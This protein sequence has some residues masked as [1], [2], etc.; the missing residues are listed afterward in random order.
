[1]SLM[2]KKL[3]EHFMKKNWKKNQK[4]FRKEKV[5]KRKG[6]KLCVKCKGYDKLFNSWIEK[7]DIVKSICKK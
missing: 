6:S 5:I 7:K 2:V 3:L 1:M 4:E